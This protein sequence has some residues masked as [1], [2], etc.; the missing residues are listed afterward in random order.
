MENIM[1][2]RAGG[3]TN[4]F[5]MVLT[6]ANPVTFSGAAVTSGVG[7]VDNVMTNT[8]GV[9]QTVVTINL[10]GVIDIQTITVGLFDV[11]DGIHSGDVGTRM[12]MLIGDVNANR[13]VNAADVSLVKSNSG[14]GVS[15]ANFR[16]DVNAN[17]AISAADVSLVKSKSGNGLP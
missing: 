8:D 16:S 6:F 11:N 10:S 4:V 7:Q 9:G 14:T 15:Q 1:S 3:A 2:Y 12:G 17:G 13:S 5:K